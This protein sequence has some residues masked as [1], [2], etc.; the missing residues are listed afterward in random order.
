MMNQFLKTFA[1]GPVRAGDATPPSLFQAVH[2]PARKGG[3]E[4]EKLGGFHEA[5]R[6][7][8]E[9]VVF[10]FSELTSTIGAVD[11]LFQEFSKISEDLQAQVSRNLELDRDNERLRTERS[12]LDE[13]IEAVETERSSAE[14]RLRIIEASVETYRAEARRATE[15]AKQLEVRAEEAVSEANG[16]RRE[17]NT[18]QPLY[19]DLNDEAAR[20]HQ[21]MDEVIHELSAARSSGDALE[22]RLIAE[23]E[24]L[25]TERKA[26]SELNLRYVEARQ[27]LSE[28]EQA[29]SRLI[30]KVEQMQS[31]IARLKEVDR[32][33]RLVAEEERAKRE[34]D[35]AA[36]EAR[37]FAVR[38]RTELV[39]RLLEKARDELRVL[40]DSSRRADQLAARLAKAE[41][42]LVATRGELVNA[43]D[44]SMELQA[45]RDA[46]VVR[47]DEYSRKYA[48]QEEEIRRLTAEKL[49][50]RRDTEFVIAA[51]QKDVQKL[52]TQVRI[53][54]DQ[55]LKEKSERAY[56]EGALDTARR[57]R[58]QLQR[59]ASELKRED[60][61]AVIAAAETE[62]NEPTALRRS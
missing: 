52:Q 42:A 39:E 2:P 47:L 45:S 23:T 9:S 15:L 44:E 40:V 14:Q 33:L 19:A 26:L 27:Q 48:E 30:A 3:S 59:I 21:R 50:Q 29:E 46:I 57:D 32:E 43:K 62:T 58:L 24:A 51:Q 1:K 8:C 13:R 7:K 4:T 28:R 12:A 41:E 22:L 18:I 6:L 35:A 60:V 11:D 16:L 10:K 34:T 20:L 37:L 61:A 38:S 36:Y 31:E 56:A 54:Q 25:Q 5:L 17:L 53:L 55:L 49:D